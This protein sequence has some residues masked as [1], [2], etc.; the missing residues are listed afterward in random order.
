MA[1]KRKN[2]SSLRRASTPVQDE[3][4]TAIDNSEVAETPDKE[5]Y[6]I[7]NDPWTDEQET[8]LFKGVI[9]WKPAG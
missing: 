5:N 6:D 4:A 3:E 1:P 7:L 8:S 9:R 2:R